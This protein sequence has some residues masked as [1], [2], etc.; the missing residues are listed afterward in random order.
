MT[1]E[2]LLTETQWREMY[3]WDEL[4][5]ENEDYVAVINRCIGTMKGSNC[6]ELKWLREV[7][8]EQNV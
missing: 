7:L 5:A 6:L 1:E 8:K 3:G 4:Q 2:K